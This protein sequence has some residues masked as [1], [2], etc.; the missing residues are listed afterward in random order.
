MIGQLLPNTN[1]MLQCIL[2]IQI[3]DLNTAVMESAAIIFI[4]KC[5]ARLF[6]FR[7]RKFYSDLCISYALNQSLKRS[8]SL[9]KNNKLSNSSQEEEK[10]MQ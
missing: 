9:A 4:Y 5:T 1:E 7:K 6:L 3:L 8:T 10:T 2:A